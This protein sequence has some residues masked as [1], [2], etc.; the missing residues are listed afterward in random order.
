MSDP[1]SEF[2]EESHQEKSPRVNLNMKK[3]QGN[4]GFCIRASGG[5]NAMKKLV[6]ILNDIDLSKHQIDEEVRP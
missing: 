2:V 1:L 4:A 5:K 6:E 3:S